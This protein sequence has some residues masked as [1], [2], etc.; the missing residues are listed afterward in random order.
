MFVPANN[1]G[2]DRIELSLRMLGGV[3]VMI[4]LL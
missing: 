3:L 2:A 1:S 4:A